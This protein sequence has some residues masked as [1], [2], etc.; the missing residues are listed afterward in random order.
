M[1]TYFAYSTTH[2]RYAGGS[3]TY[4][5]SLTTDQGTD[6]INKQKKHIGFQCD[7]TEWWQR[8][9]YWKRHH[10]PYNCAISCFLWT[11]PT[12]KAW[13]TWQTPGLNKHTFLHRHTEE[14]FKSLFTEV[15]LHLRNDLKYNI[16][17]KLTTAKSVKLPKKTA[18]KLFCKLLFTILV[19]ETKWKC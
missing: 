4:S 18:H 3:K 13:P 10:G 7:N 8:S 6:T 9:Q 12:K 5:L 19:S 14:M 16:S 17:E 15:I 2:I 1:P 11:V